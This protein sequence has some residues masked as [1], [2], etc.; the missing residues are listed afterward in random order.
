MACRYKITEISN[1]FILETEWDC[2]GGKT[3]N[4]VCV[5][6]GEKR[7]ALSNLFDKIKRIYE[8]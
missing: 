2:E 6:E 5:F 7:D 8:P 4:E 3:D 1:G